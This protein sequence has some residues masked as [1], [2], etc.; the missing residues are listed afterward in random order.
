MRGPQNGIQYINFT[1]SSLMHFFISILGGKI[2]TT[3]NV[4]QDN[5]KHLDLLIEQKKKE[6]S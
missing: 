1:K 4:L 3:S 5:I 6:N 2:C